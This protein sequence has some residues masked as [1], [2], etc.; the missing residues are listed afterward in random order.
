VTSPTG[1]EKEK[2]IVSQVF[3]SFLETLA[4]E[5]EFDRIVLGRLRIALLRDRDPDLSK[6]RTVLEDEEI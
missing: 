6:I 3:S 5:P 2:N 4:L 1:A